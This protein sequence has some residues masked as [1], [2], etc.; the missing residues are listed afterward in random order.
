MVLQVVICIVRVQ[1]V[2]V[3]NKVIL[4]SVTV[5]VRVERERRRGSYTSFLS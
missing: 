3:M 1:L 2:F 5:P 4:S